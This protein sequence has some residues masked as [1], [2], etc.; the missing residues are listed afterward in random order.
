MENKRKIS[1]IEY[2]FA[3]NRIDALLPL[4]TE[5]TPLNDP[6]SIELRL[7]SDVVWEYEEEH[8][9][10][11]IPSPAELIAEAIH[12]QNITQ[13]ELAKTLGVSKSRISNFVSGTSTPSLSL[14]GRICEILNINPALML[15]I[16]NY[17]SF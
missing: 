7:M 16:A 14:A 13:T 11:D 9:P 5:E 8:Y 10:M 1:E 2:N 3:L 12:E 15:G 6:N 17:K 4:V